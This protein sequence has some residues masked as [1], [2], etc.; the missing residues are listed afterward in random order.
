MAAPRSGFGCSTSVCECVDALVFYNAVFVQ[1][2][3]IAVL[4]AGFWACQDRGPGKTRD[5]KRKRFQQKDMPRKTRWQDKGCHEK[6]M[7]RE[8]DVKRNRCQENNMLYASSRKGCQ[9]K[10]ASRERTVKRKRYLAKGIPRQRG[11]T[12]T[13]CQERNNFWSAK[14][15]ERDVKRKA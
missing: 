7:L 9:D 8:R 4:I 14:R 6:E 10:E 13:N 15:I 2:S 12:R 1:R 3:R 5:A 11:A